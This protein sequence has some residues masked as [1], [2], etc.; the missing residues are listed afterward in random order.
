MNDLLF[1]VK[2][3]GGGVGRQ[4]SP[5]GYDVE[6]GLTTQQSERGKEMDDFFKRVSPET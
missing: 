6:A 4:V 1:S 2:G 5:M 3:E